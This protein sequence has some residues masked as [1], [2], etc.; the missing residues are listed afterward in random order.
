MK[1]VVFEQLGNIVL[2]VILLIASCQTVAISK[3]SSSYESFSSEMNFNYT[4]FLF[5]VGIILF[6]LGRSFYAKKVGIEDGYNKKAGEFSA[7]DE[8]EILVGAEAAK[9]T[10]RVLVYFLAIAFVGSMFASMFITSSTTLRI[11]PLIA[12]GSCLIITFLTYL[13]AWIILDNKI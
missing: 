5:I 13:V 6:S 12:I 9:V 1:K 4:W 10:Y 11:V 2:T 7:H 3:V 8:R